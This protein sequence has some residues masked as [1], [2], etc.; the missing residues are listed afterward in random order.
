MGVYFA[1]VVAPRGANTQNS[2]DGA[3]PGDFFDLQNVQVLKGPQGTLFG[4][5]STGGAILITPQRPTEELEGYLEGS[6]GNYDMWRTQG[7]FNTPA[8]DRV[9]LRFGS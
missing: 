3:G 7:V 4:R 2:G 6:A 8:G 9:R 5:N 1:E